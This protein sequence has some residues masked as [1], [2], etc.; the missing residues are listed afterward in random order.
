M[1]KARQGRTERVEQSRVEQPLDRIEF[2]KRKR[3]GLTLGVNNEGVNAGEMEGVNISEMVKGKP[4]FLTLS[5]GQVLDRANQPKPNKHLP[6]MVS[7]NSSNALRFGKGT[8]TEKAAKLLMICNALDKEVTGLTGKVNLLSQ[9][10]YGVSG[11][12][13]TQVKASLQ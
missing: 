4:R 3:K 11:P 8:D 5:D 12:T 6:A 2:I 10:R 7:C 9:V 13:F 1:K